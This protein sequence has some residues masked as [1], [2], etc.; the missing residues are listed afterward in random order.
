MEAISS[1]I[2]LFI[3]QYLLSIYIRHNSSLG[4]DDAVM[5]KTQK[6]TKK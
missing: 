6:G 5:D 3:P 4:T 2:H 1:F